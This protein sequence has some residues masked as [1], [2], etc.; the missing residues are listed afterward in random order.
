MIKID[1]SIVIADDSAEVLD[2]TV[3]IAEKTLQGS[4]I[5]ICGGGGSLYAVLGKTDTDA[6]LVITGLNMPKKDWRKS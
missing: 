3:R 2:R 5:I 4:G 6:G 1:G